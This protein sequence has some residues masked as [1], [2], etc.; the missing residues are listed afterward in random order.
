MV[1]TQLDKR[2]IHDERVRAVM[3]RLPRHRFVLG[4]AD[5]YM[6]GPV[7]I[8]HGQTISQPYMVAIMTQELD[9]RGSE[10][11]LEVGTGS[12]YQTAVLASLCAEVFTVERIEALLAR[13]RAL[14]QDLGFTNVR[15][16]LVDGSGGWP[17]HSPYDRILVTAAAQ[18][19][20]TALTSQLADNGLL[21]APVGDPDGYQRLVRVRRV[22]NGLETSYGIGCR[23]VP[24]V[25]GVA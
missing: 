19:V 9:L 22:G 18:A 14:L 6:D 5:A 3:S 7:P 20:P 16:A 11:V 13:S 15:S 21:V 17:Q 12:G 8:G 4:A 23:F 24:L 25:P 10:R 1:R 2:D